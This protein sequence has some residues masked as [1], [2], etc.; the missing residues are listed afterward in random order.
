[1]MVFCHGGTSQRLAVAI[2]RGDIDI[3]ALTD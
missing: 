3:V 2:N 1:M